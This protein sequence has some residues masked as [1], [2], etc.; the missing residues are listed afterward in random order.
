M[1]LGIH[2]MIIVYSALQQDEQVYQALKVK[3]VDYLLPVLLNLSFNNGLRHY[4]KQRKKQFEVS[5]KKP[6]CLA[7][8]KRLLI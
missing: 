1:L 5:L 6:S 2:L 8:H 4:F 3:S 7:I